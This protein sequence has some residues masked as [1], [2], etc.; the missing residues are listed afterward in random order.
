MRNSFSQ[1]L[2]RDQLKCTLYALHDN[3]VR[4]HRL[5]SLA[6]R[7]REQGCGDTKPSQNRCRLAMLRLGSVMFVLGK[8]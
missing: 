3:A 5:R 7:Q 4:V 2:E 8:T 1:V 6:Q